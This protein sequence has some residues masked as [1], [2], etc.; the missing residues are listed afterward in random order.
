M[1][2]SAR[3]KGITLI[4]LTLVIGMIVILTII[5][6]NVYENY[7]IAASDAA[8]KDDLRNAYKAAQALSAD[9]PNRLVT[10]SKLKSYGFRSSP[11]VNFEIYNNNSAGLLMGAAHTSPGT[12][13]FLVDVRGDIIPASR[14]L[15]EHTQ[16]GQLAS[17]GPAAGGSGAQP[18]GTTESSVPLAILELQTAYAAAISYFAHSPDGSINKNVLEKYG[19]NSN[20][21]ANLAIADGSLPGLSMVAT[22]TDSGG[23]AFIIDSFGHIR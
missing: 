19:F 16:V 20:P 12:H 3:E 6:V 15:L 17:T 7:K 5:G 23:Q 8:A 9:E 22:S 1:K 10:K 21:Q 4:E 18:S 13:V 11:S 14:S 2:I